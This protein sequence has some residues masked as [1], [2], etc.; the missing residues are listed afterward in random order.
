MD[1]VHVVNPCHSGYQEDIT[2]NLAHNTIF[3]P[4]TGRP[5]PQMSALISISLMSVCV[6]VCLYVCIVC[7]CVHARE[8]RI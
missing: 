3:I 1:S 5:P 6:S 2:V 7:M 4:K 8:R